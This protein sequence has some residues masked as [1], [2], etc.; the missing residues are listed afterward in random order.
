MTPVGTGS[1]AQFRV[2]MVVTATVCELLRVP[3]NERRLLHLPMSPTE[4]V[5]RGYYCRAGGTRAPAPQGPSLWV[6]KGE[7]QSELWTRC[8]LAVLL[9]VRRRLPNMRPDGVMT[10]RSGRML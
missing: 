5:E 10:L 8:A 4:L 3:D 7:S 6:K 2:F 1:C 9:T